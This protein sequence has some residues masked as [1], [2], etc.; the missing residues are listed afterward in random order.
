MELLQQIVQTNT[1]ICF[2]HILPVVITLKTLI[3][4]LGEAPAEPKDRKKI[5]QE[6]GHRLNNNLSKQFLDEK[7]RQAAEPL[8]LNRYE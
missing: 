5:T 1:E 3:D 8:Y 2:Q 4:F 6:G 7:K